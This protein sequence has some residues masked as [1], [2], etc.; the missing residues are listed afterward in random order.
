[1]NVLGSFCIFQP[2]APMELTEDEKRELLNL[3]RMSIRAA[4]RDEPLPV[5]DT[6]NKKFLE[7]AAVFVTLRIDGDLRGCIGYIEARLPLGEAIREVAIRSA[8]NDPRF[9]PLAEEEFD[10]IEIEISILSPLRPVES[11]EEIVVGRHG[12]VIDDGR[13]RGLLLPHV[14]IEYHWTREEFLRHTCLKAGLLEDCWRRPG[15]TLSVFTTLT[16]SEA[17]MHHPING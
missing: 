12:L 1:L 4:L 11:V 7:P 2:E 8:F 13:H 10:R 16:F 6:S 15:V 17:A 14:P 3:A 5:I 9:P